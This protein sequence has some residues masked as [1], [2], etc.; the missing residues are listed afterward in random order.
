MTELL[1]EIL[2]EEI[3]ARLQLGGAEDLRKIISRKLQE[4]DLSFDIATAYVTPRR[5]TVVVNGLPSQQPDQVEERKG[6]RITA[7]EQAIEGFLKSVGCTSLDDVGIE[8]RNVKG[9]E[10]Y[11]VKR[12]LHGRSTSSLLPGLISDS[13]V[14]LRWPKSMRWGVGRL[15]WVRPIHS[16][17]CVFNGVR[18]EGQINF[19]TV[20]GQSVSNSISFGN[21]TQGHRILAP[22]FFRVRN[23][24]EYKIELHKSFV[25]LETEE[26]QRRISQALEI[27]A[28]KYGLSTREND[29]L[30]IENAGL[31]EWPVILSGT[32]D[33]EFLELPEE[34]LTTS[35]QTHQK[36]FPLYD[37][38]GA[39]AP[40][41]VMVA[42]LETK[43]QGAR[44]IKGNERVLR[45]RLYDAKFF[46]DSDLKISLDSHS[47]RLRDITLHA[48]LGSVGDKV[49]RLRTVGV[50]VAE[51]ISG[52]NPD[53]VSRAALLC[54][55]DLATEMVGEFPELQGVMGKYYALYQN[56]NNEVAE[57]IEEHYK[58][59]GPN[60]MCP[61]SSTSVTLALS[62]KLDVLVSMFGIG[63]RPTGSKDPYALRRAALGVIRLIL[64][65]NIRVPLSEILLIS[66][67]SFENGTLEEYSSYKDSLVSFIT[68]R[69][70]VYLRELGY[71]HEVVSSAFAVAEDDDV[72][73]LTS[74]VKA[75]KDFLMTP[76]A[77]DLLKA[78]N[79]ASNIVKIEEK[80]DGANYTSEANKEL[81]V[82]QAE[83]NLFTR[84]VS[85]HQKVHD[86]LNREDFASV[87]EEVANLKEPVD[88]FFNDVT[89]NVED[90]KLRRNR[91]Y[92]LGQIRDSLKTVA[93]FS[94][95]KG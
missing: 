31:V 86:A 67:N 5:I 87:M 55:A 85:F 94:L 52:A 76:S 13:V 77:P 14:E 25:V 11:F 39:L 12:L 18:L 26:R 7:S 21:M 20:L 40:R 65:N 16:I 74:R 71:N 27:L 2:S 58:P 79:R 38:E 78:Y 42:N 70:K 93:D 88:Q 29:R 33:S 92:L 82:E 62:D 72:W 80:K 69:L 35:M 32:F 34:V 6:P 56:E 45:A 8:I 1:V 30:I 28:K 49:E 91:L 24:K 9:T 50:S 66:H 47:K 83:R 64:E 17:L 51:V 23:F 48:K 3:P 41:F 61:T 57:A 81:L 37:E 54:K 84:L 22:K 95:I 73:R 89:V 68:E 15:R 43:D 46:W 10:F 63:E 75:L 60:D 59:Q 4:L 90:L 19:D 36:Y 44:I 53:W